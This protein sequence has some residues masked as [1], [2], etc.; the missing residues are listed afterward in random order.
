MHILSNKTKCKRESKTVTTN[1]N[2]PSELD[3]FPSALLK[4]CASLDGVD[5]EGQDHTKNWGSFLNPMGRDTH[6]ES[7]LYFLLDYLC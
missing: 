6:M 3:P 4:Q 1:V 5:K 2:V 7:P